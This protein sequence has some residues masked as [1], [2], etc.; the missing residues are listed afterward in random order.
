M[1]GPVTFVPTEPPE[2]YLYLIDRV[3][4]KVDQVSEGL[5]RRMDIFEQRM[6]RL[7]LVGMGLLVA[8]VGNLT[9]MVITLASGT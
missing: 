7:L 4:A 5:G 9:V 8:L 2:L 3:E 6:N 1:D